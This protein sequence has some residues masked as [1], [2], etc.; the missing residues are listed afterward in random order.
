MIADQ[1]HAVAVVRQFVAGQ[2]R[3]EQEAGHVSA[4][5]DTELVAELMV[6]ISASFLTIPSRIVDLDD[7]EQVAALA[8]RILVPML[9]PPPGGVA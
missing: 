9:E 1:G 5:V 8:R 2:L 6:R 4:A 3:R 7:N